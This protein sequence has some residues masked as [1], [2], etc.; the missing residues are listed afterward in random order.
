MVFGTGRICNHNDFSLKSPIC[1]YNSFLNPYESSSGI[2]KNLFELRENFA[3]GKN[4]Y[5]YPKSK[6]YYV[7][8][9]IIMILLVSFIFP[10]K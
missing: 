5:T 4:R 3:T 9:F 10:K 6:L 7:F 1:D 2:D 8:L